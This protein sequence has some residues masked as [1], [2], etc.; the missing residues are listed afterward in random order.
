MSGCKVEPELDFGSDHLPVHIKLEWTW[1][2]PELRRRRAWKRLEREETRNEVQKGT[3]ILATILGRLPLETT[4]HLDSYTDK[5]ITTL[6]EIADETIPDAQPFTGSKSYWNAG[7][8]KVTRTAK[9]AIK[10][11]RHSRNTET[12][13][14]L[15]QAERDKVG[16]IRRARTLAY[17][18]AVHGASLRTT[19]VWKLA[20]WGR[21]RSTLPKELP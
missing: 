20:K 1:E 4:R 15:R 17:R 18:E 2:E 12:E 21:E 13:E 19:G 6:R 10:E 3:D 16:Q 14:R 7:C 9:D 11:Y 8:S 5:L